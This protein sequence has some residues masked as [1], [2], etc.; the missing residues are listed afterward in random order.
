MTTHVSADLVSRLCDHVAEH[1]GLHLPPDHR[2]D[3]EKRLAAAAAEQG[4]EDV[5]QFGEWLMSASLTR[6]QV[7]LLASHLTVGETY[8]F[9]D[10][11][12]WAAIESEVLPELIASRRADGRHLRIWSA[13]CCTGEEPYSV[14]MLLSNMIHDIDDWNITILATDI[15]PRFLKKAEDG[16]Y[17]EWSFR[18]APA[19][20]KERYFGSAA[21]GR[22]ILAPRIRRMVRFSH[23]N[24]VLRHA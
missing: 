8:F 4:F 21:S 22:F 20:L 7:E 14:A 24:L 15:N 9:R 19:W 1:M 2:P 23:L 13:G 12:T 16:V 18:S 17:T 5:E 10:K 11:S 6:A 3:I